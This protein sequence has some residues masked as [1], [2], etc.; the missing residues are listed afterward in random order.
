M[1]M[2]DSAEQGII[3]GVSG[4]AASVRALRWAG[5]TAQRR[6]LPL[7]VILAWESGQFAAYAQVDGH[8]GLVTQERAA[9]ERLAAALRQAFGPAP[10]SGL[11]TEVVQGSA[12]RILVDRSAG[13]ELL[14]LGSAAVSRHPGT[15]IGPVIRGC[16]SSARCPVAVIGAGPVPGT[17]G[18]PA[19]SRRA[20]ALAA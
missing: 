4:S 11:R 14:V 16:L 18:Y 19:Q 20:G 5:E 3:A 12:E 10:P 7:R 15:Q 13:A 8:P 17:A 2:S 6:H 9:H 1:A